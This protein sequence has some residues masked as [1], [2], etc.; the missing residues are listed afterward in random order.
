M[1]TN[2]KIT[3]MY[4]ARLTQLNPQLA[5]VFHLRLDA[6]LREDD[7]FYEINMTELV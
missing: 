3:G 6:E 4:P 2:E 1:A 5:C 7:I